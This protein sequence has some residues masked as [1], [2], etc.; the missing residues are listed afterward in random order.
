MIVELLNGELD[1][2]TP[3]RIDR[4]AGVI[5][6][7]PSFFRKS[8]D[9]QRFILQ[10]ELGHYVLDTSDEYAA[11]R[12]AADRMLDE[13]YGMRRTFTAMNQSLHDT[14][15]NDARRVVLFNYLARK[16]R[17]E[18]GNAEMKT[19][20]NM[21]YDADADRMFE[22]Q[23][24]EIPG[25]SGFVF[26]NNYIPNIDAPI[27]KIEESEFVNWCRFTGNPVIAVRMLPVFRAEKRRAWDNATQ[28]QKNIKEVLAQL[29]SGQLS[30][31]DATALISAIKGKGGAVSSYFNSGSDGSA[32]DTT[33]AAK[34]S[35]SGIVVI[36]AVLAVVVLLAVLVKKRKIK[37]PFK[38]K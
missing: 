31:Q 17:N 27:A 30:S 1:T 5:Q 12:Y 9:Q 20:D 14:G 2:C 29:N 15:I 28:K 35:G 10:H 6:F 25:D 26:T 8:S 32:A 37:N 7:A 23:Y 24:Q 21:I 33:D 4:R 11:D 36:V 34:K 16:D 38:K 3:A 19:V 18:N 22:I 13:D